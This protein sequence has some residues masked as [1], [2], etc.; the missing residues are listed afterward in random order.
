MADRRELLAKSVTNIHLYNRL[1]KTKFNMPA[2]ARAAVIAM[3]ARAKN[4]D[5]SYRL[6]D[7]EVINTSLLFYVFTMVAQW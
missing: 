2:H 3:E 5:D 7:P 1:S 6:T 4:G